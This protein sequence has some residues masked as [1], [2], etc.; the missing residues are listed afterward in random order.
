MRVSRI[1]L[2]FALMMIVANATFAQKVSTDYNKSADFAQYK[3]FM[4]IK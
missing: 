2:G 3:T 4:C 1:F